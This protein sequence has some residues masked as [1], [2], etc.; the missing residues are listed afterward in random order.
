LY[1]VMDCMATTA[2][3][4]KQIRFTDPSD[5]KEDTHAEQPRL[6]LRACLC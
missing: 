2:W 6:T 3:S 5:P 4:L 1:T